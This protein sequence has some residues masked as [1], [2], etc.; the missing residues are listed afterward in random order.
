M[1]E[2]IGVEPHDRISHRGEKS[3]TKLLVVIF[4]IG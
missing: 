3:D 2:V 4:I 1:N